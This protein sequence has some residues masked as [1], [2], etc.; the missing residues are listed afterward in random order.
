MDAETV[1][2]IND[3]PSRVRR[4]GNE[5]EG[6]RIKEAVICLC[7]MTQNAWLSGDAICGCMCEQQRR[8][9]TTMPRPSTSKYSYS[10]CST[11]VI[12]ARTRYS[13]L[14]EAKTGDA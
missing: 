10:Y 13:E 2:P 4:E 1:F 9:G 12:G 7:R 3:I 5:S 14:G 11:G 8:R 6:M